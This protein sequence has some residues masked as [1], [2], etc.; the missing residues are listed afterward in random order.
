[1]GRMMPVKLKSVTNA[2]NTAITRWNVIKSRSHYC[3]T[4]LQWSC[5]AHRC[6][7]R[8]GHWWLSSCNDFN[9]ATGICSNCAWL[10]Y[11]NTHS[12][13]FKVLIQSTSM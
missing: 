8:T 2:Q 13:E 11:R 9:G 4:F 3:Y 6:R 12:L 5:K 7:M 1:M 10:C